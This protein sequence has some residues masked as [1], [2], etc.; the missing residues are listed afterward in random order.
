MEWKVYKMANRLVKKIIL[1]VFTCINREEEWDIFIYI[2]IFIIETEVC[3]VLK[4]Y[5]IVFPHSFFWVVILWADVCIFS[6]HSRN[7]R[8]IEGGFLRGTKL[9]L[10]SSTQKV[11]DISPCMTIK[12]S[13]KWQ[14]IVLFQVFLCLTSFWRWV[15]LASFVSFLMVTCIMPVHCRP[16]TWI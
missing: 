16:P 13:E 9:S 8:H 2:Y 1:K 7:S 5:Y 10:K 4:N 15:C 6:A 12:P 11:F 14:E 3:F